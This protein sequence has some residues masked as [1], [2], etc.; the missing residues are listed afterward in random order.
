MEGLQPL[1]NGDG[2]ARVTHLQLAQLNGAHAPAP[3]VTPAASAPLWPP[4]GIQRDIGAA[5]GAQ[6]S[7]EDLSFITE[8][9]GQ[10]GRNQTELTTLSVS[11]VRRVRPSLA[12]FMVPPGSVD[13]NLLDWQSSALQGKGGSSADLEEGA[14]EQ[15]RV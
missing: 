10:T 13:I 14:R 9:I 5:T 8:D 7:E 12:C 6:Q 15:P 3:H 4:S 1:T 11:S 2:W